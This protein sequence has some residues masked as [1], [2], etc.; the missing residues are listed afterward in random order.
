MGMGEG[1]YWDVW[2]AIWR[3]GIEVVNDRRTTEDTMTYA[4]FLRASS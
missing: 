3:S 4:S 1:T 2:H